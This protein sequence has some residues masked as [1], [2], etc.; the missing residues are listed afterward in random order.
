MKVTGKHKV[1]AALLAAGLTALIVDRASTGPNPA[2]AAVAETAQVAS[3]PAGV[4]ATAAAPETRL[5][6][7][8][9]LAASLRAMMSSEKMSPEAAPDAF[10]PSKSWAPLVEAA[11]VRPK[12]NPPVEYFTKTHVLSALV[13]SA[14]GG[15]AVIN[16]SM[17]KIGDMVDGFKLTS[18]SQNC[19]VFQNGANSVKLQMKEAFDNADDGAKQ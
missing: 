7:A 13:H 14:K 2:D 5:S 4:P 16:G 3:A 1:Y 18:L 15:M 6:S 12:I 8:S 19:A 17:T 9:S 10:V 11:P